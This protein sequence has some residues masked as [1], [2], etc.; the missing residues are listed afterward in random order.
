MRSSMQ[1][2]AAGDSP[3]LQPGASAGLGCCVAV[4]VLLEGALVGALGTLAVRVQLLALDAVRG[5][6]RLG[7]R[8]LAR[9]PAGAAVRG[10]ACAAPARGR[11][12]SNIRHAGCGAMAVACGQLLVVTSLLLTQRRASPI[13]ACLPSCGSLQTLRCAGHAHVMNL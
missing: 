2:H 13:L 5:A 10:H 11:A 4:G 6:A 9:L 8:A 1:Q 3:V 7:V 12:A